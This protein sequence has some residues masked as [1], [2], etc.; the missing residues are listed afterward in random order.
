MNKCEIE[1]EQLH[2]IVFICTDSIGSLI[3]YGSLPKQLYFIVRLDVDKINRMGREQCSIKR[4]SIRITRASSPSTL[5]ISES[6]LESESELRSTSLFLN[7]GK[8]GKFRLVEVCKT[9]A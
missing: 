7:I 5:C 8:L 9:Q 3:H 2:A 6:E 4:Y 1:L